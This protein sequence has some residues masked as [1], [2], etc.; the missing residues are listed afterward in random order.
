MTSI[1]VKYN[2][3]GLGV[4]PPHPTRRRGPAGSPPGS[5]GE[6]A[7]RAAGGAGAGE[8]WPR[9]GPP[10]GTYGPPSTAPGA[11]GPGGDG[12]RPAAPGGNA[13]GL[14]EASPTLSASA[15]PLKREP[16][17][18]K[19]RGGPRFRTQVQ[20]IGWLQ[21]EITPREALSTG[22]GELRRAVLRR[23]AFLDITAG[24]SAGHRPGARTCAR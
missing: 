21:S 5:P 2:S 19:P 9:P 8:T 15:G 18:P 3:V 11:G 24:D 13:G 10:W 12:S 22:R 20:A 16:P 23:R 17:L 14:P 7:R 6:P 1:S 4:L